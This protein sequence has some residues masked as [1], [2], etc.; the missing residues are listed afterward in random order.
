M[1]V[2]R[3]HVRSWQAAYRT[4]L[5]NDYLDQLRPEDRARKYNFGSPDVSKPWTVVAVERAKSMGS[6]LPRQR[7]MRMCRDREKF[8]RSM[9][10]PFAG[11]AAWELRLSQRLVP[12]LWTS[13]PRMR[14]FGCW[15]ATVVRNVSMM[16]TGGCPMACAE[17]IRYRAYRLTKSVISAC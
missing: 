17:P 5:P 4:L 12:G 2:A 7:V 1:S 14:C 16:W 10:I 6:P 8:G 11:A 3:V 13:G 9:S 15:L